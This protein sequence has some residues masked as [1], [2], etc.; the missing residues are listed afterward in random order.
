MITEFNIVGR[1][2]IGSGWEKINVVGSHDRWEVVINVIFT[3]IYVLSTI[4]VINA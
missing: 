3:L 1:Y 4:W 2:I